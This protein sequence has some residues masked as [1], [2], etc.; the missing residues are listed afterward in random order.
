MHVTRSPGATSMFETGDPSEH[1]APVRSQPDAC[2]WVIEYPDPGTTLPKKWMSCPIVVKL[3][4]DSP[5]PVVKDHCWVCSSGSALTWTTISP[6]LRF[7]NV[8]VTCSPA[9]TSM[10]E[11]GEPSEHVAEVRSHGM[12]GVV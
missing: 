8:H 6:R 5:P 3:D 7:V 12:D 4:G 2:S 9:L 10:F 1:V 11:T